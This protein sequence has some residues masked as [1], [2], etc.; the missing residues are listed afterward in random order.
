MNIDPNRLAVEYYFGDLQ[1]WKLPQIA[2]E[3][4]ERGHDGPALRRLAAMAARPA[5]ALREED[6]RAVDNDSGFREMGVDAPIPK[7]KARL[8]L[9][10]ES[11]HRAINGR[12]NVF[13]EAT[14]IRIHLCELSDPPESLRQIVHLSKRAQNAPRSQWGQLETDLQEAFAMFLNSQGPE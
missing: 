8:A 6:I 2:I 4:L 9:A 12:S 1:Y 3:A 7:G 10:I 5:S 13:D 14:H 11:A